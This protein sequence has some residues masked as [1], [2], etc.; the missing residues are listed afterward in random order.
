MANEK[1]CDRRFAGATVDVEVC[2]KV[3]KKFRLSD[4]DS[5]SVIYARALEESVRDVELTKSDLLAIA[6]EIEANRRE[7]EEKRNKKSSK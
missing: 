5:L 2:Y 1:K 4:Q 7:R 6:E 3:E